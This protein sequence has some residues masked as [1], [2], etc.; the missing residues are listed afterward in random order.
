MSDRILLAFCACPNEELA[1]A[2]AKTLVTEGLAACVTLLPGLGS[3]YLWEGTL[4][5]DTEVMLLIK[6]AEDRF[7]TLSARLRDLHPYDLPEI[8]ALPVTHGLPDYL[9]WVLACTSPAS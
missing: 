1:S 9:Q 4:Q 5:R 6:T 3:F 8:I 7:D 2:L